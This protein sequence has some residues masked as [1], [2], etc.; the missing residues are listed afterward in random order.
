MVGKIIKFIRIKRNLK[1]SDLAKLINTSES[2]ISHYEQ[3]YSSVSLER[4]KDIADVCNIRIIFLDEVTGEQYSFSDVERIQSDIRVRNK[5]K[6][7]TV[8]YKVVNKK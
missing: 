7:K 6:D 5:K 4:I 3:D 2:T 1:Q 8:T